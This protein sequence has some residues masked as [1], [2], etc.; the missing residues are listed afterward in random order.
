VSELYAGLSSQVFGWGATS[1][2]CMNNTLHPWGNRPDNPHRAQVQEL[3]RQ[4]IYASGGVPGANDFDIQGPD[5]YPSDGRALPHSYR[6]MTGGNPRLE[7]ENADTWTFG[8]VWQAR[9]RNLTISADWYEIDIDNVVGS[10]GFLAAYQQCFNANGTS[11]P[12]YDPNNEYCQRITRDPVN[13]EPLLVYGGNFNFSQRLTS[14][15]DVSLNWSAP[16]QNLGLNV[17]GDVGVRTSANKLLTWKQ[18]QFQE[19]DS[20]MIE[21]AGYGTD[22]DYQLFTTFFY[23][24]D[25]L[26]VGLNWRHMP[27]Q[28]AAARA[29][30]PEATTLPT[31]SYDLFNLNGS[32]RFTDTLRLRGGIDNLFDTDPP[33]TARNPNNPGNPSNGTGVTNAANYDALGRRYFVGIAVT[34]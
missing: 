21:Y 31:K 29:T 10:L 5:N 30:N 28:I 34:F 20:P 9:N 12:T 19:P 11:N 17:P 24:R 16:L 8:V 18:P 3:C 2:V 15:V 13:A 26:N 4:L 23:N 27:E 6:L 1:D 25:R 22:F 32:W 33:L 7:A 14:G